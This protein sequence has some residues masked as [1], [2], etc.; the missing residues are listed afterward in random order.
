SKTLGEKGTWLFREW[1]RQSVAQNK[2]YDQ[3]VRELITAQGSSFTNPAVNY[4]RALR[5]T[6]KI[7]EDVSQTFLGVRF[8]CNKCHDHPFERWTQDQYYQFGAFFARVAFKPGAKPGE[9]TVYA[10]YR[11]GEGMHPRTGATMSPTVPFGAE[12]D[13]QHARVR[14]DAF[15]DWLTSKDNPLFARSYVNRVWSYFFGRGIIEPVD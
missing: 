15:A 9:E 13:V 12:P 1:I 11:G 14:E 5:D 6:G 3:F 8:N 10:N 7:T 2:P 4:Y